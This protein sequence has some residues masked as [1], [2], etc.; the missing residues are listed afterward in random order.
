MI[1]KIKRKKKLLFQQ[2]KF[3]VFLILRPVLK[4]MSAP[5]KKAKDFSFAFL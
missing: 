1:Y 4:V 2:L 3:D 5:Q